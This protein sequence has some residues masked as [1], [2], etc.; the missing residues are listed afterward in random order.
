[1]ATIEQFEFCLANGY[2]RSETFKCSL[3]E[4]IKECESNS[5]FMNTRNWLYQK[6][7]GKFKEIGHTTLDGYFWKY[8][9]I[10]NGGCKSH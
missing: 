10:S 7:A 5:R 4:A 2:A 3:Q 9:E 6:I 1:M 8:M